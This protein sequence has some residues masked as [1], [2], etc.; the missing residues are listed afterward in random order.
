MVYPIMVGAGK[1]LFDQT[2]ATK[3]LQLVET[4]TVGDGIHILIYRPASR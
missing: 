4:N 3:R 2:S 1:R